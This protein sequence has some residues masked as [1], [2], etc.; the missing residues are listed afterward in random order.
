MRIISNNLDFVNAI[1]S[2]KV[3]GYTEFDAVVLTFNDIKVLRE[4]RG[5]FDK[6]IEPLYYKE[7]LA[8]WLHLQYKV[9]TGWIKSL[10]Q[11]YLL[12]DDCI[13]LIQ[14]TH[15]G[16]NAYM[17]SSNVDNI[18]MN[19]VCFLAGLTDKE[20]NVFISIPHTWGNNLNKVDNE[21]INN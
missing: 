3:N 6:N 5:N 2:Q 21:K 15:N 9:D 10:R 19:D 20:L 13:S 7:I 11:Q 1:K 12:S 18:L 17:R 16:V 4:L 14:L 8:R